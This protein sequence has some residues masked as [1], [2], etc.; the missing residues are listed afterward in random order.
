[1]KW[2]NALLNDPDYLNYLDQIQQAEKKRIYCHHQLPHLLDVARI[3][4]LLNCERDLGFTKDLIYLSA[5][6]HD[7]GRVVEYHTPSEN[8]AQAGLH[9]A[10]DLLTNIQ[11][12]KEQQALIL[13]SIAFHRSEGN[14]S[15]FA[16]L[17]READHLSRPCLLCPAQETCY[18]PDAKKNFTLSY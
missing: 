5:L 3:A 7:I 2:T 14:V 18:W 8:H 13:D 4:A 15:S 9:L 6:L 16:E 12:P 11:V 1:M 17:I 10:Q